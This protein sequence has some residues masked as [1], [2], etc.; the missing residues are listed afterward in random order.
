MPP[1]EA[2]WRKDAPMTDMPPPFLTLEAMSKD[3]GMEDYEPALSL[4]LPEH[5][6][7]EL[8]DEAREQ[9]LDYLD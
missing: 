3:D 2:I 7:L 4:P 6:T 1:I 5:P 9:V 8:L